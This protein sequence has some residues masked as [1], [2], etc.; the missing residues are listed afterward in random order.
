[1][2]FIRHMAGSI[3]APLSAFERVP[4]YG[5]RKTPVR[6]PTSPR[7]YYPPAHRD[8]WRKKMSQAQE[9]EMADDAE[10]ENDEQDEDEPTREWIQF[11]GKT[12]ELAEDIAQPPG[13]MN[14]PAA[15]AMSHWDTFAGFASN[16]EVE[17]LLDVLG[18]LPEHEEFHPNMEAYRRKIAKLTQ[19][20][21]DSPRYE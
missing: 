11:R 7:V 17:G 2:V 16:E 20:K 4:A 10:A 1:M 15:R 12:R 21:L 14:K 13:H 18:K 8:S 19:E 5:S 9:A 6:N 3:S